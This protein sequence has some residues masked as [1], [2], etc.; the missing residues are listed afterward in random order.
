MN[1]LLINCSTGRQVSTSSAEAG[2]SVCGISRYI[3]VL[4]CWACSLSF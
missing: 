1:I 4:S 2:I 3:N